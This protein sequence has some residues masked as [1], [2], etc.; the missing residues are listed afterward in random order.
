MLQTSRSIERRGTNR[1]P[2]AFTLQYHRAGEE[3]WRGGWTVD[4][5]SGG[6]AFL[7]ADE[8][9]PAIDEEVEILAQQPLV[10]A[11]VKAPTPLLGRVTRVEDQNGVTRKVAVTFRN[12]PGI[13]AAIPTN[14]DNSGCGV[15][16][17]TAPIERV[18]PA[19]LPAVNQRQA[20]A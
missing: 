5:S 17:R 2:A 11:S 4:M 9:A 7:T 15:S 18:F 10:A 16:S 12:A 3:K 1:K 6:A 8:S 14:I 19:G 13:C 20:F